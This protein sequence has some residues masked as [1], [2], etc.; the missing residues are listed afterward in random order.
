MSAAIRREGGAEYLQVKTL[1]PSRS[2]ERYA[3]TRAFYAALGFRSL[4]EL[5]TLWNSE[6]PCLIMVKRLLAG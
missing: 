2:D 5:H 6:N 4:E 1:G 3:A